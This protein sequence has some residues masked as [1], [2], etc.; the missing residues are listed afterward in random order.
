MSLAPLR[1]FALLC[2]VVL[3][4]LSAAG[5]FEN[6]PALGDES[7]LLFELVISKDQMVSGESVEIRVILR[8]KTPNPVEVTFPTEKTTDL[9]ITNAA[10]QDQVYSYAADRTFDQGQTKVMVRE[11][12]INT[13]LKIQWE[14]FYSNGTAVP[15]GDYRVVAAAADHSQWLAEGPLKVI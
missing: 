9:L 2:T 11:F 7:D 1:V 5:C 14:G 6:D 3:L 13:L 8:N 15:E 4:T 12:S 10:T